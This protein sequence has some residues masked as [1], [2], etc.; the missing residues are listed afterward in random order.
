MIHD[1]PGCYSSGTAPPIQEVAA[2]REGNITR[3]SGSYGTCELHGCES[4][5]KRGIEVGNVL[6]IINRRHSTGISVSVREREGDGRGER[7]TETNRQTEMKELRGRE[8]MK[9]KFVFET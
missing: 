2:L 7:E 3:I 6:T 9:V 4:V 1:V 8:R 5:L